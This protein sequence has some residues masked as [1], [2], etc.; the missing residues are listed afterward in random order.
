MGRSVSFASGSV[1]IAYQVPELTY[2]DDEGVEHYDES[3]LWDDY[4]ENLQYQIEN[5]FPSMKPCEVWLDRE[6]LAIMENSHA[7][8]GVSEYCGMVSIWLKPKYANYI[9]L[10]SE[11]CIPDAIA[12]RH[13][14]A[15]RYWCN[16]VKDKFMKT[17][18][19]YNKM[20]TA[21]N[22]CSF[23]QVEASFS[24][25]RDKASRRAEV[26]K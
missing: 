25:L 14:N 17:F 23:Y 5:I 3:Y 20:G 2:T 10:N 22:G 26:S 12:S 16:Q 13:N 11:E 1:A 18:N 15:A 7:F 6:D 9:W 24:S 8:I 21:S 19:Q 4:K